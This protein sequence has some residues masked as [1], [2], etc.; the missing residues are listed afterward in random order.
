[1]QA[2][3]RFETDRLMEGTIEFLKWFDGRAKAFKS[4]GM[5]CD[6]EWSNKKTISAVVLCE[7]LPNFLRYS[8]SDD[9]CCRLFL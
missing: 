8:Y 9:R 1:M 4:G 7:I 2:D 3:V 5:L 6:R